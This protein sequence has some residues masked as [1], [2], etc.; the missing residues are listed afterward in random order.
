MVF[1]FVWLTSLSMIISRS[2]HVAANGIISFFLWLSNILLYIYIYH[3]FF[4]DSTVN[5]H[6]GCF[7][8]LAIV[9][10]DALNIG[11]K[12]THLKH[13]FLWILTNLYTHVTINLNQNIEIFHQ[14]EKFP[15]APSQSSPPTPSKHWSAFCAH[16][17]DLSFLDLHLNKIVHYLLFSVL[18]SFTKHNVFEHHPCLYMYQ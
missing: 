5:G 16:R 13:M 9:N 3:I 7:Y 15:S 8:L 12:C 11:V 4:I 18:T 17:L 14:G 1:V 2:I 10:S 6:L